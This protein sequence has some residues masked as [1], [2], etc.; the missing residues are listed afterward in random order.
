VG[1]SSRS[2]PEQWLR[3]IEE[4]YRQGRLAEA[5]EELAAFRKRFPDHEL[6]PSLRER[7]PAKSGR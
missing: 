7:L 3:D 2:R 1:A 5:Q 6:P 4:L